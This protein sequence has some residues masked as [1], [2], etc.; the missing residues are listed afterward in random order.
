VAE[1]TPCIPWTGA[2]NRD[3]YG[4]HRAVYIR[5]VGP[6]PVGLEIDHLCRNRSC[7][8]VEHMEL[9]TH[10][11]NS[12]RRYGTHCR[13]GHE[14]TAES[15]YAGRGKRECRVCSAARQRRFQ[16]AKKALS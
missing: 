8:N 6:I 13:N 2:L 4:Q 15:T 10:A 1:L 16:A 3:G 9:V 12:R 11:E 14:Y 7:V 5:A